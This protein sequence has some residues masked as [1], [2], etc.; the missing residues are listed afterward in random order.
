MLILTRVDLE[1]LL[2][3]EEL[4]RVLRQLKGEGSEVVLFVC[5]T[6]R[7]YF[8]SIT[9]EEDKFMDFDRFSPSSTF[10]NLYAEPPDDHLLPC[11]ACGAEPSVVRMANA[12]RKIQVFSS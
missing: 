3:S 5:S 9:L 2:T 7:L 6:D 1:S 8:G 11:P 12:G 4:K 10:V